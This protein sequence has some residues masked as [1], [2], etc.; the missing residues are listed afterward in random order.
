[1][2]FLKLTGDRLRIYLAADHVGIVCERGLLRRRVECVSARVPSDDAGAQPWAPAVR[3]LGELIAT[4]GW[5]GLPIDVAV[6]SEFVRFALV[7]GI[8]R[9]LSSF[10]M[11][12]LAH[13]LFAR[14]LGE[15]VADWSVRYCATDRSTV[16]GAAVEKSLLAALEDFAR[17]CACTLRSVSPLWSCAANQ[18]RRRLARRSAWLVLAESRAAAFGLIERGRWRAMRA[19]ALDA[20]RGLGVARLLERESRYIGADTREVIVVGGEPGRD[21][22]A[23]DWKVEYLPLA[24]ARYGALPAECRPAALAGL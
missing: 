10:E 14:V 16:L 22:F 24:P 11:Q 19:K 15:S 20:E 5:R 2:T 6:S 21:Q 4:G 13:G 8:R 23:P 3:A 1:M 9:Q 18:Q 12:G 17:T 7:P